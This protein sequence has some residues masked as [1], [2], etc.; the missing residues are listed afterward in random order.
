MICFCVVLEPALAW[1]DCSCFLSCWSIYIRLVT[2]GERVPTACLQKSFQSGGLPPPSLHTA[3]PSATR[4]SVSRCHSSDGGED[5]R[6]L[7]CSS[8][9]FWFWK[10]LWLSNMIC[11]YDVSIISAMNVAMCLNVCKSTSSAW[12][13]SY[14]RFG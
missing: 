3:I 11:W 1:L 13:L 10:S 6:K 8:G 14:Y 12:L 4:R 2:S 5:W 9:P 7:F